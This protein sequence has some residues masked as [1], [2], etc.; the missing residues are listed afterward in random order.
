MITVITPT[1]RP[2]YLNITKE[3]LEN[4]TYTDFEW[5]VEPGLARNG[6]TLPKDLNNALR[7]AKGDQILFLQDCISVDDDFLEYISTITEPTTFPL[8]KIMQK[9]DK[10]QF[11]WRKEAS[12]D[13]QPREWEIDLAVAPKKMFFDIGGFDEEFCRGWSFDNVE[14]AYRA[15]MAGWKFK[16]DNKKWGIAIDHDKQVQHPFRDTRELNDVRAQNSKRMADIGE[17]K[18]DYI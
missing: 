14:V 4:Q 10:P 15:S 2:E 9:G 13:I 12:R 6:F 7:R 8:G 5:L 1:I 3:V 11:D 17:W 18:L 16:C